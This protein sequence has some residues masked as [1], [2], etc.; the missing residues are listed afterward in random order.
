MIYKYI[1]AIMTKVC[2]TLQFND[3][4]GALIAEMVFM[5]NPYYL[6]RIIPA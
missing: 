2:E 3:L 6:N 4:L 5:A 1:K